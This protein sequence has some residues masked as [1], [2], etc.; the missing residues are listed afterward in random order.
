MLELPM[1]DGAEGL[2]VKFLLQMTIEKTARDKRE[3]QDEEDAKIHLGR[4]Y[5]PQ[6][7]SEKDA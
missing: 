2:S 5:D 7:H 1:T 3:D 6:R 4:I